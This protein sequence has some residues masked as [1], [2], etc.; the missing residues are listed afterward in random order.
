MIPC[1]LVGN[2]KIKH[3]KKKKTKSYKSLCQCKSRFEDSHEEK[4]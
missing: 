3:K 2:I 4:V 1:L